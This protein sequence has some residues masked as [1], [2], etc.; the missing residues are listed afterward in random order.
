MTGQST[1]GQGAETYADTVK[2]IVGADNDHAT[3]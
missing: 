1:P 2:R 3:G